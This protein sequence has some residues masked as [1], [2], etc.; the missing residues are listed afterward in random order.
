MYL[1]IQ[2]L[3]TVVAVYVST[4]NTLICRCLQ[5]RGVSDQQE[6]FIKDF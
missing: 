1:F 5:I 4:S 6:V 2:Y 3:L